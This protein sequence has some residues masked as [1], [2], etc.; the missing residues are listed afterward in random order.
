M[1]RKHSVSPDQTHSKLTAPKLSAIATACALA[2]TSTAYAQSNGIVVSA[3][4][5][6]NS[7]VTQTLDAFGYEMRL[8]SAQNNS[9]V[10]AAEVLSNTLTASF[11][12]G[13]DA[14]LTISGNSVSAAT[15]GNQAS[16]SADLGLLGSGINPF[17]IA[18]AN[19]QLRNTGASTAT[20]DNQ[21]IEARSVD[22]QFAPTTISGNSV[23]ASVGLNNAST[24]VAGTPARAF[25]SEEPVG[26]TLANNATLVIAS[27]NIA[28]VNAQTASN[29][30][31]NSG[32]RAAVTQS[33]IVA[34]ATG[35]PADG[36]NALSEAVT[37][38]NNAIAAG[39][40]SNTATTVYQS[41]PGSTAFK[42]GVIVANVQTD[43]E[44]APQTEA[45]TALIQNA[46]ITADVRQ[47]GGTNVLA[48]PVTI[49][50]NRMV[51]SSSG[52][53]AGELDA[54]GRVLAGNALI[55]ESAS[56]VSSNLDSS[57]L[58]VGSL[59]QASGTRYDSSIEGSTITARADSIAAGGSVTLRDNSLVASANANIAGNLAS[60]TANAVGTNLRVS[61]EQA[62]LQTVV[63]ASV[64]D[65]SISA[66]IQDG[67]LGSAESVTLS[68]NQIGATAGANTAANTLV[69]R[70]TS[71]TGRTDSVSLQTINDT[72]IQAAVS[73]ASIEA[74]V[75]EAG[76][77]SMAI[78][79]SRN[80]LSA[81]AT[82]NAYT[83]T[84]SLQA[85][86]L[87][88][89]Q[90][91]FSNFTQST[92]NASGLQ[93]SASNTASVSSKVTGDVADSRLTL[94][95]NSIA[96]AAIANRSSQFSE[97]VATNF[98]NQQTSVESLQSA[99]G[100]ISASTSAVNSLTVSRGASV[101]GS[102]LTSTGN[103]AQSQAIGN[104]ASNTLAVS[105][106]LASGSG[107]SFNVNSSQYAE[108]SVSAVSTASQ[109][110]LARGQIDN[111]S[112]TQS[113]NSIS[114]AA[115]GQGVSNR[116]QITTSSLSG[117]TANVFNA[118]ERFGGDVTASVVAA[119][120]LVSD[121]TLFGVS[122]N[123]ASSSPITIS[124][125]RAEASAMQ[126]DAFNVLQA[127]A[128]SLVT[129]TGSAALVVDNQQ[130]SAGSSSA[131]VSSALVGLTANSLSS[132]NA[133]VSDNRLTAS[134]GINT[135]TNAIVVDATSALN[136]IGN[137]NSNQVASGAVDASIGSSSG[138]SQTTL[139][140]VPLNGRIALNGVNATV[141]GN[142]MMAQG[143][144]NAATNILNASSS[145][146]IGNAGAV[147]PVATYALNSQQN[148]SGSVSTRVTNAQL[149]VSA[150][151]VEGSA[152]T[153]SGNTFA[154]LSTANTATN[155]M[156]L[157]AMP[158]S[159]M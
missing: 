150:G 47:L 30:S 49:S 130:A 11:A 61:N 35:A 126:N 15:L 48:A 144:A 90:T 92:Q 14:A 3:T 12:S 93:L 16:N 142:L 57:S 122:T 104:T 50:G 8:L 76:I 133:V 96:S 51:A 143:T 9:A 139:G 75:S 62:S 135:A 155:Q 85:A 5:L 157:S 106:T 127:A 100:D 2:F 38:S 148:S 74:N 58:S 43:I 91:G 23:S 88:T 22:S 111:S 154:A 89:A 115:L 34:S 32:S 73:N 125:N 69:Q 39:F 156:T 116:L 36:S 63:N 138:G 4:N 79:T 10:I 120:G 46:S 153:I 70:A 27:A 129:Q 25:N 60:V 145:N 86:Q 110:I 72:A 26:T 45:P 56:S 29:A 149:G 118:Q 158:G 134:A 99:N 33:T 95:D 108:G 101:L 18:A 131:S 28:V 13:P 97:I 42:G 113:N 107:G 20:V 103:L 152:L 137:V 136:A 19:S 53:R 82:G 84:T 1:K 80:S 6:L 65:P 68:G 7:D 132:G 54:T 64:S 40:A 44:T 37:I 55:I 87:G 151:S 24:R 112:I 71:I 124:G 159:T 102:S 52:N 31:G 78:G 41:T 21:L 117:S 119:P 17:A 114:A 81:V 147:A 140:I 146:P 59:Q 105:A 128:T 94:S 66:R 121:A 109:E 123:Q 98:S 83:G 141:S 77:S 67:N